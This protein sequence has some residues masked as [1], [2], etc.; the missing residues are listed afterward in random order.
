MTQRYEVA[1]IIEFLFEK[2]KTSGAKRQQKEEKKNF[3]LSISFEVIF[4]SARF[5]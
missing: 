1:I 2:S 5:D 3:L 4:L